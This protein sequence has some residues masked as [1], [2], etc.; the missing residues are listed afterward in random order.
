MDGTGTGARKDRSAL[1][2]LTATMASEESY[3]GTGGG[4]KKSS[5][6]F[7][8]CDAEG[9]PNFLEKIHRFV[10]SDGT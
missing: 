2:H 1:C 5:A 9:M 4:P 6:R 7:H 10:S 8:R 3:L